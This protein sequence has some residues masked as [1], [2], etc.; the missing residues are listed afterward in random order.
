MARPKGTGGRSAYDKYR[1]FTRRSKSARLRKTYKLRNAKG[2]FM[3]KSTASRYD[4]G[5]KKPRYHGKKS[6]FDK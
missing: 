3:K 4:K 6:R 5:Y 2:Q 1:K